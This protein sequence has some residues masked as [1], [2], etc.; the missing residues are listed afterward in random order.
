M[1]VPGPRL[2]GRATGRPVERRRS[3]RGA[4]PTPGPLL[5][6]FRRA[7][8]PVRD[9]GHRATCPVKGTARLWSIEAPADDSSDI[10]WSFTDP[11]PGLS[12]LSGL[13]AFDHDRVRG[14][15][16]RRPPRRRPA[17]RHRQAVPHVGRRRPPDP[18]PR[19]AP[20]TRW[21]LP[22]APRRPTGAAR[23]SRAARCSHSRSW[24]PVA[25][26]REGDRSRHLVFTRAADA[27][28]RSL[29]ARRG[30]RRPDLHHA[31]VHACRAAARAAGTLLLDVTAPDVI[32]HAVA[33]RRRRPD[34]SA[35]STCP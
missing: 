32:R 9:E 11:G 25:T 12:W 2:V 27:G 6:V 34:A 24:P 33:A 14:P 35:P 4:R 20:P 21:P 8:R 16:R 22:P 1:S 7:S 18:A 28:S 19:R 26:R 13:A 31:S 23:S 29:R 5:S 15:A 10:V 17:G 30:R 3:G